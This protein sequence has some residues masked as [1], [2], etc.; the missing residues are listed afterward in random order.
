MSQAIA[1]AKAFD[2]T[3]QKNDWRTPKPFFEMLNGLFK[4]RLDPC[5]T[6]DNPLGTEHFFTLENDGLSQPWVYNAFVNPPYSRK[7]TD[8]P[9][10][11]PAFHWIVYADYAAR[12][13]NT[14]NV[15]LIAARPDT[16]AMHYALKHSRAVVFLK[17]RL[18]FEGAPANAK[19]PSALIIFS[20]KSKMRPEQQKVLS[21]MGTIIL[22]GGTDVIPYTGKLE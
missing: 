16:K 18:S 7:A 3:P 20:S 14:T 9:K 11:K 19:F 22:C 5:T 13:N 17:H 4:F 12:Y 6:A 8:N 2:E 1:A 21:G 15:C 10:I